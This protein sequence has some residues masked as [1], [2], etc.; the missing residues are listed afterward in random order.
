MYSKIRR[1][2]MFI[3]ATMLIA[4]YVV[5]MAAAIMD[6]GIDRVNN[7]HETLR[8]PYLDSKREIQHFM[9]LILAEHSKN[10]TL[11]NNTFAITKIDEFLIQ[12]KTINSLRFI[13]SDFTFYRE[14]FLLSS[15]QYPYGN[16][17]S[18]MVY[19]SQI[20]GEFSFKMSSVSSSIIINEFFEISFV[21]LAE[22][23]NN[24]VTIQQSI[25][26]EYEYV[27]AASIYISNG[28][29][30][31]IPEVNPSRTGIYSFTGVSSLDNLGVLNIT[32]NNGVHIFS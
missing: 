2:Q 5:M 19:K 21:G 15:K 22:V 20:Y 10:G 23:Q 8:D 17:S 25:G 30:Q 12:L 1:G 3:L 32:L 28:S 16:I 31:I 24:D 26:N 9:E 11:M 13:T 14:S 4:V 7:D 29:A 18:D 6:I 27:E